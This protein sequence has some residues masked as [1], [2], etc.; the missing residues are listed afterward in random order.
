MNDLSK[1]SEANRKIVIGND[2]YQ[3]K[4]KQWH[5]LMTAYLGGEAWANAGYLTR[6]TLETDDE[7]VARIKA[8][9]LEN[10][11]SSV[12]SV[13]NSFLF[14]QPPTRYLDKIENDTATQ[15]FLWDAD[16]D[17][18]T[19]THFMKEAATWASVFGH[20]W[21]LMSKPNVGA[22]T[23]ADEIA[24]GVRPYV[25]LFTPLTVLDWTYKRER[26][27]KINL[28]YLRYVEDITDHLY[29]VKEWYTDRITTYVVD[30]KRDIKVD[31]YTEVNGLGKIPAVCVYNGRGLRR[32]E[33]ISDITDIANLQK[34]IY[35][36]TSEVEQS[37]RIDSH[38][39]LVK[40]TNT[41]A[42]AG[43]GSVLTMPDDMDPGLKPYVLEFSGAEVDK[44]YAAINHSIEAIDK[45]ANVGAVRATETRV[46]SA[47]AMET[48]FQLLNARLSQKADNLE[49]AEEQLWNLFA[50]YQGTVWDGLI[51]YPGS[52]NLRDTTSE[53]NQLKVAKETAT[54]ESTLKL[55]DE[56]IVEWLD[57][58]SGEQ[59]TS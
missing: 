18:R 19:L 3:F 1:L 23:A 39:S 45:I 29:T 34:F 56:K 10:H 35:N 5:Y 51:Q 42:G 27:G 33:G 6:Y 44:I 25:S 53:I 31:E 28:T 26:T 37:I 40:T 11:C 9:P 41:S 50:E 32:G 46:M 57:K 58:D 49:L 55:I 38:P 20:C 47:V 16:F 7:Y 21:I 13:Y 15:D 36:C 48:E 4:I 12:I 30:T 54:E 14:R 8:T 17:G 52:F 24:T 59:S 22:I 43:T 2:T